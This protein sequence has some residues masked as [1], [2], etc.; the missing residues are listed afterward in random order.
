MFKLTGEILQKLCPEMPL[1][2]ANF[3]AGLLVFICPKYGIDTADKFHEFI[4]NV[5]HESGG[6]NILSESLNYS[7]KGLLE[8]FSRKRISEQDC[9]RLGRTPARAAEQAQI[10]WALYGGDWG[11]ANLGNN[12]PNDGWIFRGAGPIQITG[13]ENITRFANYYNKL[14]STAYTPEEM[15]DLLKRDIGVGIHSACWIFA[16]SMNLINDAVNDNMAVIVKRINGGT[17]GMPDRM[18]YYELAKEYI[19]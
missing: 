14:N 9:K 17:I 6:F 19:V 8:T 13:R 3:I 18:K 15:A 16:I 7:I 1:N 12:K 2:K 10:A 5:L 11:R 4:A